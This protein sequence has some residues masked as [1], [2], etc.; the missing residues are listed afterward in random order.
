MW[1]R[2]GFGPLRPGTSY[3]RVAGSDSVG[4]SGSSAGVFPAGCLP[5]LHVH[6][7]ALN[8]FV[9]HFLQGDVLGLLPH[10]RPTSSP[11]LVLPGH[12]HVFLSR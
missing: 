8:T 11:S 4:N 9:C 1:K 6:T 12:L 10:G 7:P 2:L 3:V 5:S